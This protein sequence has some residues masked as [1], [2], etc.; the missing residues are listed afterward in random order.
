VRNREEG[1]NQ[2]FSLRYMVKLRLLDIYMDTESEES[3]AW[4]S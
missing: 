1:Q 2:E 3:G 4:E